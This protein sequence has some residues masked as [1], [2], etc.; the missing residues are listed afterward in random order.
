MNST[1]PVSYYPASIHIDL[2][3]FVQM[4]S[5]EDLVKFIRAQIDVSLGCEAPELDGMAKALF[6]AHEGIKSRID[7]ARIRNA[8]TGRKPRKPRKP[9]NREGTGDDIQEAFDGEYYEYQ[10]EVS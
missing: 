2:L 3:P 7:A 1:T 6:T 5:D 4:T 9:R 10:E 8:E